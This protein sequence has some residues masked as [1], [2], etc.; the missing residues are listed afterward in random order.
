[1]HKTANLLAQV[2]I[3]NCLKPDTFPMPVAAKITVIKN[4]SLKIID[5][6]NMTIT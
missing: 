3:L 4:T 6:I 2:K 5:A 1:M